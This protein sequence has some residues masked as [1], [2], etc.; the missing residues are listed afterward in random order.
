[1]VMNVERLRPERG[2]RSAERGSS[3]SPERGALCGAGL[4][5]PRACETAHLAW[6]AASASCAPDPDLNPDSSPQHINSVSVHAG[7]LKS[8][9]S[10]ETR[11]GYGTTR[12]PVW[13]GSFW[14]VRGSETQLYSCAVISPHRGTR[15]SAGAPSQLL[16][17]Q[18][19]CRAQRA[20]SL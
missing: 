16:P 4:G 14:K 9:C 19:A 15:D 17:T 2:A 3:G 10:E 7:T 8:S 11:P 12:C 20:Q 18:R 5:Q 6:N 13:A 1:M